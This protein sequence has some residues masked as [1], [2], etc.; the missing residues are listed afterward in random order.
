MLNGNSFH[1][2]GAAQVIE[3][4]PSVALDLKRGQLIKTLSLEFLRLYLGG[5]LREMR[6]DK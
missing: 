2:F 1:S 3:R 5:S 4:S 6:D